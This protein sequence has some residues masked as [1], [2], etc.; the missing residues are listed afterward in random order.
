[1]AMSSQASPLRLQDPFPPLM[2]A[3]GFY[4]YGTVS[5][6]TFF[7]WLSFIF[8]TNEPWI[9]VGHTSFSHQ[10]IMIRLLSLN[11]DRNKQ[12]PDWSPI[13]IK[14]SSTQARPSLST[15]C[16]ERTSKINL[17]ALARHKNCSS[18]SA[19][20]S[21]CALQAAHILSASHPAEK[22]RK[23]HVAGTPPDASPGV[24]SRA[25]LKSA[26]LRNMLFLREDLHDAWADYEFGIDPDVRHLAL[27]PHDEYRIVAFIS[28]HKS[29]AGH[30]I[31]MRAMADPG[32]RPFDR[33]L[34]DHFAQAVLK[35]IKG[36]GER[37]RDLRRV[38]VSLSNTKTWVPF[39][40]KGGLEL[41]LDSPLLD[42][43]DD[44]RQQ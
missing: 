39:A 43:D 24:P 38:S 8:D 17:R 11:L 14:L 10:V 12:P 41:E 4:Q 18:T 1:M 32:T 5:W 34:R 6:A 3:T 30:Y 36:R 21:W 13:D 29:I 25:S 33:L 42:E 7:R 2:L 44:L 26:S 23:D 22:N 20:L 28:G 19:E 15:I 9:I 31:E 35:H 27:T 40:A 16:H 37:H